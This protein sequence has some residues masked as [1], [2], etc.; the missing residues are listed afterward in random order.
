M[1]PVVAFIVTFIVATAGS[2]GAKVM[3]TKQAPAGPATADSTS[4]AD[5]TSTDTAVV[6]SGQPVAPP[7]D[8]AVHAVAPAAPDTSKHGTPAVKTPVPGTTP[9]GPVQTGA[10]KAGAVSGATPRTAA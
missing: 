7:I 1:K 10:A 5:E 3:M 9:S 6:A 4:H 2:A 8:T